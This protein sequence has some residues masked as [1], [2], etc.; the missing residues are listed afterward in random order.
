MTILRSKSWADLIDSIVEKA[1]EGEPYAFIYR[2]P[3]PQIPIPFQPI[4]TTSSTSNTNTAAHLPPPVTNEIVDQILALKVKLPYPIE[5]R[6]NLY[7]L[8]NYLP[9]DATFTNLHKEW[10][11]T[12]LDY[13]LKD[14]ELEKELN[15]SSDRKNNPLYKKWGT[16]RKNISNYESKLLFNLLNKGYRAKMIVGGAFLEPTDSTSYK[17]SVLIKFTQT[18]EVTAVV[19]PAEPLRPTPTVSQTPQNFIPLYSLSRTD[20]ST[21]RVNTQ[22][23]TEEET[24]LPPQASKSQRSA[25]G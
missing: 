18:A 5:E 9:A 15:K 23:S 16:V 22:S 21:I 20:L 11:S 3:Q 6:I 17:I 19:K 2:N 1:L 4:V 10:L 14:G 24:P 7:H 12:L 13:I 8:L 25:R